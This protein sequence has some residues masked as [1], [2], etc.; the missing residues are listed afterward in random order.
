M[1]RGNR[2]APVAVEP[3]VATLPGGVEVHGYAEVHAPYA[4]QRLR[5]Y[6]ASPTATG[7]VSFD[8]VRAAL[9]VID[10]LEE[11]LAQAGF[12]LASA[13]SGER[14]SV[15]VWLMA[16]ADALDA[17]EGDATEAGNALRQSAI[18]LLNM[19]DLSA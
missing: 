18:Q 7:M 14:R 11:K 3:I 2:T 13:R 1:K 19:K 4:V 9:V 16:R 12:V 10:R 17:A 6:V 5:E 15:S 8:A